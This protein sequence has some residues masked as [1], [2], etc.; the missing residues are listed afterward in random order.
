MKKVKKHTQEPAEEHQIEDIQHL[1]TI[2]L[3]EGPEACQVCGC[4]F[5]GGD[6]ATAYAFRAAGNSIFE[7]GYVMC[8]A[9]EHAHPTG[10]IRG[11]HELVVTGRIGRC[12]DV[13]A[14]S[15]WLVLIE[16]DP[17]VES[18]PRSRDAH[19]IDETTPRET[20]SPTNGPQTLLAAACDD[21]Q[22]DGGTN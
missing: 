20:E 13:A 2:A 17:V 6:G 8:G 15:S 4:E 12:S 7:I 9:D 5:R 22:P 1:K 3:G 16:L 14:Q 11:V 21:R 19:V 10:F 18:R